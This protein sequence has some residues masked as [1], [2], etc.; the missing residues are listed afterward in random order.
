MVRVTALAIV[1]GLSGAA[2]IT[3][4][5][6]ENPPPVNA[7]PGQSNDPGAVLGRVKQRYTDLNPL[8]IRLIQTYQ[9]LT[10]TAG[11]E[12]VSS[13][14]TL[15]TY[16]QGLNER[17]VLITSTLNRPPQI[18]MTTG[19]SGAAV[20]RLE[21]LRTADGIQIQFQPVAS[22]PQ[23]HPQVTTFQVSSQTLDPQLRALM[24]DPLATLQTFDIVAGSNPS[25]REEYLNGVEEYVITTRDP[26]E[27]SPGVRADLQFWIG[28]KSFLVDRM[29]ATFQIK[30]PEQTTSTFVDFVSDFRYEFNVA[31]PAGFFVLPPFHQL[32]ELATPP[33][34]PQAAVQAPGR[35]QDVTPLLLRDRDFLLKNYKH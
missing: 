5:L 32:G 11:D 10:R 16:Q 26:V 15:V 21:W 23:D 8:P 24:S 25:I 7:P 30:L 31:I 33:L 19:Y 6:A 35:M 28:M 18:G 27:L 2:D 13:T 17:T 20:G 9:T 34:T 4:A 22:G 14:G 1:A 29:S 12:D 3:A